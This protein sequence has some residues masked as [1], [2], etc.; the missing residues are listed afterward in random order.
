METLRH[1]H[2]L[3]SS[4]KLTKHACE[5]TVSDTTYSIPPNSNVQVNFSGLHTNTKTWGSSAMA[6][7]PAR[8]ITSDDAQ[9]G[10]GVNVEQLRAFP[11]GV[12]V[13]WSHGER[14]C[15]GKR[16]SQVELAAVLAVLFRKH[17]VEAVPEI[18]ESELEARERAKRVSLD[19]QMSLLNEMYQS[20]RVGLRWAEVE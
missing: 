10:K 16:F 6:W 20:D 9:R 18:G 11:E 8:F 12:Y 1:C 19:I 17:G 15:P 14:I 7:N 4:S 13:P 3:G 5:L 2:P